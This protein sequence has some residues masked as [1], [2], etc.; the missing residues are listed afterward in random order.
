MEVMEL[1]GYLATAWVVWYVII[2]VILFMIGCVIAL[3]ILI[4]AAIFKE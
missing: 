3:A 2:P 1:I 4:I